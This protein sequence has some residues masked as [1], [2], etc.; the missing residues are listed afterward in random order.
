[1][2]VLLVGFN[3]GCPKARRVLVGV[4]SAVFQENP[5]RILVLEFFVPHLID[6]EVEWR[7]SGDSIAATAGVAH[8]CDHAASLLL[9][10]PV[11]VQLPQLPED[12]GQLISAS[13]ISSQHHPICDSTYLI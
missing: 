1:M 6:A 3:A 7:V 13:N 5:V 9:S 11:P 10:H 12:Q 2:R 8:A 4:P